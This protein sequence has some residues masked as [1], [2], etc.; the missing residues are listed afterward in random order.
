MLPWSHPALRNVQGRAVAVQAI[1]ADGSG[2]LGRSAQL[3]LEGSTKAID[4]YGWA[5]F[6]VQLTLSV[7]SS[8]ILL[9][10]V[11]FTSQVLIIMSQ[12]AQM[13]CFRWHGRY[14]QQTGSGPSSVC[15]SLA[16][17]GS[18]VS[19]VVALSQQPHGCVGW[20]MHVWPTAFEK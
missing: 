15:S 11:A 7:V 10:S 6:W 13:A 19:P 18:A 2:Q 4:L 9:F 17:P 20:R 5:S 3:A 1:A 12:Q 16:L 8:V 14:L